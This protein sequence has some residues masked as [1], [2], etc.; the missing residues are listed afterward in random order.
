MENQ[1]SSGEAT[2]SQKKA[3]YKSGWG[4]VIAILFFPYFLL[5]YMWAKTSW[6]KGVK[7]AITIVFA[8][9]NIV[10]LANNDTNKNTSQQANQQT[11]QKPAIAETKNDRAVAD[12]QEIK[13]D[14][15]SDS[16]QKTEETN[17]ILFKVS[18]VID[19]D[20][21]DI[22]MNGKI[23]RIRL[24]GMDTPETVDPRKVVQCFGKEASDKAKEMLNGK[25][26][27]LEADN[28]QGER[29][30][31]KRLLRYVYLEDGTFF[32]KYMIA[33]GYAHEYT[34]QSN[35]Y[36]YQLDFKEA[37]KQARETAKGLWS[38]ASCNGD[39]TQA[40]I[41]KSE[42]NNNSSETISPTTNN[43]SGA[44]VKK[45]KTGICH[46]PGTTYYNKTLNFTP[47]SSID[48]CLKSGGRLP[49][50]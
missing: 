24:I 21:L 14:N 20:T 38:S 48:E 18:R 28:S 43:S 16:G 29:D 8:L 25:M 33:E 22:D 46:A 6:G 44:V 39:T 11:E 40:V 23:E 4:L 45:S 49:K 30:G 31:Y 10:A 17:V 12:T 42:D 13:S 35:P 37:E 2:N 34:Y 5:W 15:I 47:Y 41:V 32:N 7:I 9:I 26:V 19:G 3:W 1:Q 27:S 36:K 50:R